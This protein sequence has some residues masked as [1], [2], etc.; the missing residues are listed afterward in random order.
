MTFRFLVAR[1]AQ[2]VPAVV[3]IVLVAFLLVHL[4]PGDPV[5]ALAG[6]HG[7]ASYYASMRDRFGLDE[8]LHQQF[9]TYAS[10]VA[11]GDLGFSYVHGRP[12]LALIAERIPA[13][14]LLT[15]VALLVAIVTAI[16]LGVLAARRA[17]DAPDLWITGVALTL[18]SAPVFWIGQLA[19]LFVALHLGLAPVQGMLDADTA[20]EGAARFLEV[21][22][23]LALPALVLASQELAVLV[24]LTRTNLIDELGRDHVRTARAKG[25]GEWGVLYR[26]ALPRALMPTI[27]VIGA[28]LGHLLAGAVVVEVVFGWPGMGRLLYSALQARDAPVML[29]LFLVVSVSV[30]LFNMVADLIHGAIDPRLRLR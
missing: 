9:M 21:L 17:H 27:T 19:M 8:P 26:H 7:D 6:E 4:A 30:V 5:L 18:Y 16:P 25:V 13:T 12:T 10:R 2:L 1:L 23:H 28:R 20:S 24:R 11:R 14:L 15:G 3:G 22:R 29:G